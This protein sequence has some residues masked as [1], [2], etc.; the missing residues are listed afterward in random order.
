MLKDEKDLSNE[1]RYN[2]KMKQKGKK[3]NSCEK[4]LS[5]DVNIH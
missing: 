4:N 2:N 3:R 1:S 5:D